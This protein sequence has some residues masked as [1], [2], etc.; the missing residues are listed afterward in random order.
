[1]SSSSQSTRARFIGEVARAARVSV[2]TV[3]YY[4]RL[5]L[6]PAAQRTEAGYR[7]YSAEAAERL[8]FIQQAQALGFSLGEI[9]E[10]LRMRYTRQS[11]CDCVRTLLGRKLEEVV[12]QMRDLHRFRRLLHR[13]LARSRTLRRLPHE[14][15]A[16]CPIIEAAPAPAGPRPQGPQREER[17]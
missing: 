2:H 3:R 5:G 13:T 6:L 7:V 8:R 4:E 10:I 16:L 12:R 9:K 11:P 15:S 14:A 17:R 1:M